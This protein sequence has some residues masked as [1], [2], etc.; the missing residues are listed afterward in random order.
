MKT[1]R[2]WLQS[3]IA[4]ASSDDVILPWAAKRID[5]V[6]TPTS[7]P[8]PVIRIFPSAPTKYAAIAAR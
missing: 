3:A 4:A 7:A 2:R 6:A 5:R 1:N 8:A